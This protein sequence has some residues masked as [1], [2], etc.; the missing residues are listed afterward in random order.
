MIHA[1][2]W[3]ALYAEVGRFVSLLSTADPATPVPTC[4]GLDLAA[5]AGHVGATHRCV[6]AMVTAGTTDELPYRPSREAIPVDVAALLSWLAEGAEKLVF[7]LAATPPE[8]PVW[9]WGPDPHARF[10]S[11][12][13]LHEAV[14]HHVDAAL[15][16]GRPVTIA[17]P[18]AEDGVD[19]FLTDLPHAGWVPGVAAVDGDGQTSALAAV[20]TGAVWR[21]R[22]D[23]AKPFWRR[24]EDTAGADVVAS[25]PVAALYLFVWGRIPARDITGDAGLLA[26][27]TAASAL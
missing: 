21:I 8:R 2:Y 5:L 9:A 25:A 10:R 11:R 14:V 4:P 19:E 3:Q 18:V 23:S 27:W 22:L 26:R 6:T 7:A 12:R 20:D 1:G 16:L 13:M 15:A 17:T 24:V